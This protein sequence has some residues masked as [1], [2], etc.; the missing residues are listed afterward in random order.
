MTLVLL[1]AVGFALGLSGLAAALR[2]EAA[3]LRSTL[4]SL[5]RPPIV[6]R[7]PGSPA[8]LAARLQRSAGDRIVAAVATRGGFPESLR[9]AAELA[10]ISLTDTCGRSA[11]WAVGAVVVG[12]LVWAAGAFTGSPP[13]LVVPLWLSLAGAA[14]GALVPWLQLRAAAATARQAARA[15]VAVYLDLVVLCLAGGMGLEGALH[16]AAEVTEGPMADRIGAALDHARHTGAA[17]WDALADL[18]ERL[19]VSELTE[20]AAAVSL[21]GI[22][23]ARI[24]STLAAKAAAIRRHQLAEAETEASTVTERLF[25]PAVLLL[26]GFLVF[27]GYPAFARIVIGL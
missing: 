21:A 19:Q 7:P 13:T 26:L 12:P 10:E 18:G 11:L 27:V 16:Q 9:Q 4:A 5:Q 14:V 15:V 25:L 23:G 1:T 17:P 22:E 2:P 8:G 6:A 20:L 3:S 24:R